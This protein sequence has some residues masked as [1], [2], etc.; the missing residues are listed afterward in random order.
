MSRP[1]AVKGGGACSKHV[2]N[3]RLSAVPRIR[4]A[5]VRNSSGTRIGSPEERCS[6]AAGAEGTS[7]PGSDDPLRPCDG[8]LGAEPICLETLYRKESPRLIRMLARRV[9]SRDEAQDLV[10]EAFARLARLGAG[11]SRHIEQPE[12]YLGQVARNLLRGRARAEA[13][14]A[15]HLHVVADE[16]RIAGHCQQ[17]HLEHRDMLARLEQVILRLKP[18]T[19]A[20]FL[21]HR[22]HGMSYAE[23]AKRTGLSQKGVEKQMAKAIAQV[24]RLMDRP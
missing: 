16:N 9:A 17:S 22:V 8:L 11:E 15:P 24:G 13:R 2:L 20:I 7:C 4:E 1:L 3:T 21:A 12:A 23:I 19:R 14:R 5:R 18:K 6:A 10:Q